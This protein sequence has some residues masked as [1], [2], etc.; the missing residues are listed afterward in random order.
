[1]DL[2]NRESFA[3]L[4]K[5][6][7][8]ESVEL[9]P[10]QFEEAWE[11]MKSVELPPYGILL[12]VV[13]C[14]MG[15]SALGGRIIDALSE[16]NQRVPI[17][18]FTGYHVP[19]YTGQQTLV[20]I[21]SYSGNTEESLASAE[22]ALQKGAKIF[23]LTTGGKL[24]EF[25]KANN[26]AYYLIDP[27]S[28]PSGQPRLALGYSVAATIALLSKLGIVEIDDEYMTQSI[29]FARSVSEEFKVDQPKT[30]NK[31]KQTAL[32]LL[33]KIPVLVASEHL[34]GAAHAFKNQLNESS[35]NFSALFELPELNHHLMEGLSHPEAAKQYLEFVAFESN[36]YTDRVQSRYKIT[37]DV[38]RK[39][40]IA[41]TVYKTNGVA[42]L[43]QVL[44]VLV[45]GSFVQFYLAMLNGVNPEPI[46][47]VNYFK[48]ELEKI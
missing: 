42:K 26:L 8:Y 3:A 44:E 37:Y 21:S 7:V 31:A 1:M 22:H 24:L 27:K 29:G 48:K 23:C 28:N 38:L 30:K 9:L 45:F 40:D 2:D 6:Q 14:G 11:G 41:H 17:E 33:D 20:I 16:D 4:D 13:I 46:P 36:L 34:T 47:W 12:N 35:K 18:V 10:N 32:E 39:N 25:A 43:A 5:S 19:F 15:G